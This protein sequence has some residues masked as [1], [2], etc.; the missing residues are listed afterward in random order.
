MAMHIYRT[1][2]DRVPIPAALLLDDRLTYAARGLLLEVLARPEG[3]E[4]NADELS[5]AAREA[6]GDAIGEGRRAIRLLFAELENAGYMR[7]LRQRAN[8]GTFYTILEVTDAPHRWSSNK[9]GQPP[10]L[11]RQGHENVVY[12]IGDGRSSVVKIG[13]TS[14]LKG[15]LRNLQTA[16]AYELQ[17]LWSCGG[18]AALEAHLHS[19]FADRQMIG[20]WFDFG[21]S[22]PVETVMASVEAFYLMPTGTCIA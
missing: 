13:T 3:W 20:E 18:G 21:D 4:T 12:V 15:R 19:D 7:R 5:R 8:S 17:V 14:N 10:R 1:T 16:S 6:R 2:A 22:D 9:A 11:P